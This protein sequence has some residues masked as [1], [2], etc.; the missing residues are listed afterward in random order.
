MNQLGG[1]GAGGIPGRSYAFAPG[2]DG[3][4]KPFYCGHR[5]NYY[6]NNNKHLIYQKKH[7]DKYTLLYTNPLI[8]IQNFNS[9]NKSNLVFLNDN[10]YKLQKD[11]TY[12]LTISIID[13]TVIF[14]VT[15]VYRETNEN[16]LYFYTKY[17]INITSQVNFSNHH[18]FRWNGNNVFNGNKYT[19][20]TGQQPE[21]K[22][23]V[24]N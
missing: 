6:L 17:N 10:G 13:V 22:I 3:T 9:E 19:S 11:K 2:A 15:A 18:I 23:Y 14:T 21:V 5:F 1:V 4:H 20:Y 24:K 16:N 7:L 8:F 12:K